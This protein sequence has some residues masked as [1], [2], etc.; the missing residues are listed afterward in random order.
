[1]RV[2]SKGQVTIPQDVRERHGL[3]PGTE[4]EF[5]DDGHGVRLRKVRGMK[6]RGHRLVEHMRGRAAAT[7]TRLSTDEIMAL[8]RGEE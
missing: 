8:T 2:T 1:M 5:V 6:R 7:T 3:L 4:V